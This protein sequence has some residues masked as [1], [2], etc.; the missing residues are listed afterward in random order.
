MS[1]GAEGTVGGGVEEW[2]V[3]GRDGTCIYGVAGW[4]VDGW[5]CGDVDRPIVA[6]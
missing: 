5:G 6:D 2:M 1:G 4:W 3:A